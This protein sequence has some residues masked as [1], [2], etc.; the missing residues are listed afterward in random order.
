MTGFRR[1]LTLT[2]LALTIALSGCSLPRGAAVQSEVIEGAGDPE[3]DFIVHPVTRE[4]VRAVA[5]WPNVAG[6]HEYSW[7]SGGG[8]GGVIAPGDTVDLIIWDTDET[9]LLVSPGARSI[10]MPGLRVSSAGYIYLPYAG[11]VKIAGKSPEAARRAIQSKLIFVSPSSEVQLSMSEGQGNSVNLVSGVGKPGSYPLV[12]G[13]QTILGL[14]AQGGGVQANIRNPRVGLQRGAQR[15]GI[16]FDHLRDRPKLDIGLRPG[17]KVFVEEDD[18]TF[19]ILGAS[20]QERL[21]NFDRDDISAREAVSIAGGLDDNRANPKSVLI[22]REYPASAVGKGPQK[23]RVVFVIDLT[24]ADGL[25]SADKFMIA[26]NDLV[27]V[28]ESPVTSVRTVFGLIGGT[29]GL[30][31]Q[32]NGL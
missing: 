29:F 11:N 4:T 16:G 7:P 23:E 13:Q 31:R 14:I 18:R 5:T 27:L 8:S 3:A 9:S 25:F 1:G 19:Q 12:D 26:P 17:D 22:L 32:A 21:V 20:G 28:T 10:P 30:A 2:C 24:T 15:Y 6:H